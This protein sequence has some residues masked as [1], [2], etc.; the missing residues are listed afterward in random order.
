M[1]DEVIDLDGDAG[2]KSLDDAIRSTSKMTEQELQKLQGTLVDQI[3]SG[4]ELHAW[5]REFLE[6]VQKTLLVHKMKRLAATKKSILPATSS[7]AHLSPKSTSQ[8]EVVNA[9]IS[10]AGAVKT[11]VILKRLTG[12]FPE[13]LVSHPRL[14]FAIKAPL[15]QIAAKKQSCLFAV[16]TG[17]GGDGLSNHIEYFKTRQRAGIAK[18]EDIDC[19]VAFI[20][21][22]PLSR[23]LLGPDLLT[24]DP[25]LS[26]LALGLILKKCL[27]VWFLKTQK[28]FLLELAVS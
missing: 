14:D 13:A 8:V 24:A 2:A 23:T 25:N 17:E 20:P 10:R 4:E 15:T 27:Q 11:L 21:P 3:S 16:I 18:S 28:I 12:S 6:H 5:S 22:G 1:N 26:Q 9:E 19:E 7:K